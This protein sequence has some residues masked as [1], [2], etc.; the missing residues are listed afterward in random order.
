MGSDG[1]EVP[2]G[3]G[4]SWQTHHKLDLGQDPIYYVDTHSLTSKGNYQDTSGVSADPVS[5][6]PQ[7]SRYSH[8]PSAVTSLK[9]GWGY[10][11]SQ[12]YRFFFL[13]TK[14]PL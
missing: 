11:M 2:V 1:E 8:F 4:R 5:N 7:I 13:E 3:N 9:E 14:S 6:S 10:Y 12:Y